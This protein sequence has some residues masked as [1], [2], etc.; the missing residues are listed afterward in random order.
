MLADQH[1][2]TAIVRCLTVREGSYR[3]PHTDCHRRLC[4]RPSLPRP[5]W[6]AIHDL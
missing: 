5:C 6:A 2:V 1:A 4:R 3:Y